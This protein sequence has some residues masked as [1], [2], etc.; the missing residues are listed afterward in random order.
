MNDLQQNVLAVLNAM[1]SIIMKL[2]NRP[3]VCFFH[4]L[5]SDVE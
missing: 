2:V 5:V 1:T 4:V 3:T